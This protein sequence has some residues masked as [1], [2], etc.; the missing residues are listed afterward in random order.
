MSTAVLALLLLAG[1]GL[2]FYALYKRATERGASEADLRL[3]RLIEQDM[4]DAVVAPEAEEEDKPKK[5]VAD[6]ETVA[7]L[8]SR[9]ERSPALHSGEGR[10]F[11]NWL[12]HQL[13][14]AGLRSDTFGPY[15]AIA[16]TLLIWSA[17]VALP[18]LA[19]TT[20]LVPTW[21]ALVCAAFFLAYPLLKLR[22]L[23]VQ[24]RD[25]IEKE[26]PFVVMELAMTMSSGMTNID[27]ALLRLV[28]N[29]ARDPEAVLVR[30]IEQAVV[31]Y[32]HGGRRREDALRDVIW[33]CG[34][35]SVETFIESIIVALQVGSP[36]TDVLQEQADH[37][38]EMWRQSMRA[39]TA[40]KM[41]VVVLRVVETMFGGLIII[42]TPL[43][44][45]LLELISGL[46]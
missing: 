29:N 44:I 23:Q 20:G 45:D 4:G 41:P 7:A 12:D 8:A 18:V 34:V 31:E 30:E 17:G 38:R 46:G 36:I 19:W 37:A 39:Y 3:A 22:S 10:S 27:D 2:I 32:R 24:R 42:A 6:S 21:V 13:H 43:F 5:T 11:L 16:L 40:R 26:L 15:R 35:T 33:R 1:L 28:R 9:L 14:M 25:D